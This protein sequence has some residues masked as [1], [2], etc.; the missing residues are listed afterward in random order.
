M[1]KILQLCVT[2]MFA[3][4]CTSV[5]A[6]DRAVS[7]TITS[8]ED[9]S[10]MPGVNI[11]LKGTTIGTVTD[12]A[13]AYTLSVPAT[14]GTLVYS[15]IGLVSQE[16]EIGTR[17]SI[18]VSM[19]LDVKQL[20]EVVVTAIG[21]ERSEKTL[22]YSATKMDERAITQGR[23]FSAMNSLQGKVAGVNISSSSGAPGA[24][25]KVIIRGYSS[26]SG[27]NSP[28]YVVDGVPINNN[29]SI[30]YD[31]GNSVQR[32][33][34]FG[35]RANDI[36][37]D[38]IASITVLKGASATALYGSRAASGVIMITTKKG[39]ANDVRVDIS[40]SAAISSPLRTPEYQNEFGQGWSGHFAFEENGSWGPKMDGKDRLWGNIVENSQQIK[41]FSPQYDN[42]KDFYET[43]TSFVNTISLSGGT[44]KASY[45]LSYGNTS[46][47]GIIPTN[48]DSYKRNSFSLR[49]S[50]TGKKITTSASLN[51]VH[52]DAKVV[53]T[54]QGG[55]GTTVF[56]EIIQVPRDI[57]IVDS[58]DINYKFN[59]LDNFYTQ[60]AQNPYYPI[61]KNGNDYNEDRLYGNVN[62]TYN[63][64]SWLNA[65]L[66]VGGDIA[67]AQVHDWIDEALITDGTPNASANDVP[68]RIDNR[69]RYT[70]DLNADFIVTANN[71]IGENIRIN[72][73]V[74]FNANDR[75]SD[76][77]HVFVRD[78]DIP[79]YF[80]IKN[81]SQPPTTN[82]T[83]SQRRL[84]GVYGQAEIGFKEYLYLTVLARNDWSSTL[85][86]NNNSFFYPGANLSLV[87]TDAFAIESNF[88]SFGKVRIGLGKTGNDAPPYSILPVF[89]AGVSNLPSGDIT[90]PLNGVNGFEVGNA[91]GNLNL[92]PEI[93]TEF[94][95]GADLRF[96]NDRVRLDAAYYNKNTDGQIMAVP[97]PTSSGYTAQTRNFGKVNN[98]GIEVL[99]N[100]NPLRLENGINWDISLNYTKNTTTLVSL[101]G[102]LERA[103][104]TGL[105][106][107][108]VGAYD[109][110]FVGYP[111]QKLGLFEGPRIATDPD[112]RIIVNPVNGLP[113]VDL[114]N[115]EILGSYQPDF[116]AG[117]TNR[118][119]FKGLALSFTFDWRKGGVMYAYTRRLMD[120][121]GNS[122][123]STYN[124]RNPFI[125]PNSVIEVVDGDGNATYDENTTAV[126][127]TNQASYWGTGPYID[128]N[129]VLDRSYVKLREV[130]LSYQL[131]QSVVSKIGFRNLEISLVGRNLLLWTPKEN[132][133]IDPELS[134][135]GNDLSG[136]FGEFG[137]GPTVRSYGVSLRA[138]F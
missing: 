34:D 9:G 121:V 64:T 132:N 75:Y 43:G 79:G 40:S 3:L 22:G 129:F 102:G 114:D 33:Q 128:R 110:D 84:L 53:T 2:A 20:S 134:T 81:S 94:E 8:T 67:N 117:L 95:V 87:F 93:T 70:R 72:S 99:F 137:S 41:P 45:Y 59:N 1:S 65:T 26:L 123:T 118:I 39:N 62:L 5:W 36:N 28:L 44:D 50:T 58:K 133:V 12:A 42:L 10:S 25:T 63:F 77:L 108:A 124:D 88:L 66:R 68:G 27:N 97:L 29:A 105:G 109:V 136:E 83:Q 125:V 119:S 23:S 61:F 47:D 74:G 80:H 6:Q 91:I 130:V 56:Q 7:G 90:F 103:D 107:F 18:D 24:S 138:G 11:V 37:P 116:V 57:S 112:G 106:G 122:T 78:L 60:Y 131:P 120:F 101:D 35:N 14:G 48:A 111:G 52:K 92:A 13:G 71:K 32:T 127:M 82:R 51:F 21:I 115:P 76:N 15:F 135:F 104:L 126:D 89:V 69:S 38:D 19:V 49:G 113:Q 17:N 98:E 54:G 85:P 30:F 73:L 46:E 16:I 31:E 100:V 86:Q 4:A 55:D 96:Y